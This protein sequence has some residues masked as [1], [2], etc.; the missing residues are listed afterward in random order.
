MSLIKQLWIAVAFLMFLAFATSFTISTLTTVKSY[1]EQLNIKNIDNVNSLA[2]ILSQVEKDKVILELML[3]AQFDTGHYHYITLYDTQG[4]VYLDKRFEASQ[5]SPVPDWFRGLFN[6]RVS[7]GIASIQDGWHQF[8]TLHLESDERFAY[9]ALWKTTQRYLFWFFLVTLSLGLIATYILKFIIKPLNNVVTQAE[10]LGGR[11]FI[12][13]KEPKTLEF[14]RVVRAMNNLTENVRRM[15]ETESQRLED[16]RYKNQHD[17]LTGA[18]NRDYFNSQLEADL[19]SEDDQ[20]IY[21]FIMFRLPELQLINQELGHK[22]TDE[23]IINL[24]NT[25]INRLDASK[26]YCNGFY[27]GRLNGSDFAVVIKEVSDFTQFLEFLV[28]DLKSNLAPYQDSVKL[29]LPIA[30]NYFKAGEKRGDVFTRLDDL[31]AQAEVEQQISLC[32]DNNCDLNSSLTGDLAGG[33]QWKKTLDSILESKQLAFSQ[34]PVVDLNNSLIHFEAMMRIKLDG[35]LV[36]AGL[37]IPWVR[38]LKLMAKFELALIEHLISRLHNQQDERLAMNISLETLRDAQIS[39]T[40]IKLMESN[41][42]VM[43]RLSLE[44]N[45]REV[46][47]HIE[48]VKIF[49]QGVQHT[50]CKLGI[51]NAGEGFAKITGLHE[52]G[53][54]YLKLSASFT[55]DID[56]KTENLE[57]VRGITTLAHSIGLSIIATGVRE[58][59]QLNSFKQVGV[60][61]MT[62]PAIR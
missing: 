44:F 61:G 15:L 46:I 28:S 60:D 20:L 27:L 47:N 52:L 7:P 34:F 14:N 17:P 31:L 3:A 11:R 5:A 29:K 57:F 43:P 54:D 59:Y 32:F 13:T 38:R 4:E 62:G 23:L 21:G 9:M 42:A 12:T 8:G 56:N 53:L 25:I 6:L 49:C 22:K 40:L 45:E 33:E 19:L 39:L 50:G 16:M 36:S 26:N 30:A 10:A 1:E 35:K 41:K 58:G 55:Q 2:L 37:F 24:V 51:D 18:A 48:L